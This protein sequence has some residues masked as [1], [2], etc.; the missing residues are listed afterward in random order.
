VILCTGLDLKLLRQSYK[1]SSVRYPKY[2][3]I[4]QLRREKN[5]ENGVNGFDEMTKMTSFT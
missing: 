4:L 2:C 3:P 1:A 5:V